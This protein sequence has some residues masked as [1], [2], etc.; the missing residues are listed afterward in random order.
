MRPALRKEYGQNRAGLTLVELMVAL[1]IFAVVAALTFTI[2]SRA[3]RT[4]RRLD[5]TY[6]LRKEIDNIASRIEN[7]LRSA[8]KIVH[9]TERDIFFIDVKFDTFSIFVREGTLF[10][11]QIPITGI[12]V[13]SLHFDYIGIRQ[14]QEIRDFSALDTWR[15]GVLDSLETTSITGVGCYCEF[16]GSSSGDLTGTTITKEFFVRLRNMPS[17]W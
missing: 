3:Q 17:G 11:N 16:F 9:G 12:S 14:G 15:D 4:Q 8:R 10:L 6:A 2:F 5:Q 1:T 7:A 13:K